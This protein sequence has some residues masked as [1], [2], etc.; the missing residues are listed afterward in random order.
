MPE[1]TYLHF[2]I[3]RTNMA[4]QELKTDFRIPRSK[5]VCF[6]RVTFTEFIFH[7]FFLREQATTIP[8]CNSFRMTRNQVA[9]TTDS[10]CLHSLASILHVLSRCTFLCSC[11]QNTTYHQELHQDCSLQEEDALHP[12]RGS[13]HA[14]FE[15]KK[16]LHRFV[17]QE[18]HLYTS[19]EVVSVVQ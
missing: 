13:I 17:F 5:R 14:N 6:I 9:E 12:V 4:I 1:S 16:H 2:L 8:I 15:S 3:T 7:N 19:N 18:A 10:A 11:T